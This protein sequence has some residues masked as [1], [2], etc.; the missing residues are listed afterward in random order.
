M[1]WFSIGIGLVAV[2]WGLRVFLK[3]DRDFRALGLPQLAASSTFIVLARAIGIAIAA[4]GAFI[5]MR[6]RN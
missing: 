4:F 1:G 5:L 2:F 6:S 3:P